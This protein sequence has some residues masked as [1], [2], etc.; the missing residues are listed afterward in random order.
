[1]KRANDASEYPGE[2]VDAYRAS[3]VPPRKRSRRPG[4][5][6][7]QAAEHTAGERAHWAST[8][9]Y[10]G[11]EKITRNKE[12]VPAPVSPPAH[13]SPTLQSASSP[14]L[15]HAS[16][17]YTHPGR[18]ESTQDR[19]WGY[20]RTQN[21]KDDIATH[22]YQ[23]QQPKIA[24]H[25]PSYD[26]ARSTAVQTTSSV[27]PTVP[28]IGATSVHSPSPSYASQGFPM[29]A[30]RS[31]RPAQN[32]SCQESTSPTQPGAAS[33]SSPS[34]ILTFRGERVNCALGALDGDP[35]GIITVLRATAASA[36]ERDKWMIVA[37]YY[38]G[39][40]NVT[41]AA[42]V[43]EA[44]LDGECSLCLRRE[45]RGRCLIPRSYVAC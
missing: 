32:T 22:R 24:P 12:N 36:L 7:R 21:V 8:N 4:K 9:A 35:A 27:V 18:S 38:R 2:S 16:S 5:R 10:H 26:L 28:N 39:A 11:V 1:M 43:V 42:R 20:T 45:C 19:Y 13:S 29:S 17:A 23:G 34:I 40:G 37:G 15:P 3:S 30:A 33:S 41:A 6:Q 14:L 44:M 31:S 25:P